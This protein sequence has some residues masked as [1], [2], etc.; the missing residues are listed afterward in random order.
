MIDWRSMSTTKQLDPSQ[1][2]L[3]RAGTMCIADTGRKPTGGWEKPTNEWRQRACV[4][5]TC[6][7]HKIFSRKSRWVYVERAVLRGDQPRTQTVSDS[8]SVNGGRQCWLVTDEIWNYSPQIKRS[9]EHWNGL[10]YSTV[11]LLSIM[12]DELVQ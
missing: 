6:D 8:K 10:Q 5:W 2:I 4:R 7:M 9:I 1:P 3:E 12:T 11:V